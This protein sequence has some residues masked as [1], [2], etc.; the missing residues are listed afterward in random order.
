MAKINWSFNLAVLTRV[1]GE[2]RIKRENK[3][4]YTERTE[5]KDTYTNQPK[6]EMHG[7]ESKK[8]NQELP[9]TLPHGVMDSVAFLAMTYDST[10]SRRILDCKKICS[11]DTCCL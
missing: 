7:A 9:V 5:G 10:Q 11:E 3:A 4:D 2:Q 8:P 1:E 6:E